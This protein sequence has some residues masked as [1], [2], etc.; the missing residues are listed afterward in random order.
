M[1]DNVVDEGAAGKTELRILEGED[2]TLALGEALGRTL[3]APC[4]V[5]LRGNLGAGKTTLTRGLLRGLGFRGAVKSPTYTIVEPYEL[6]AVTVYH[7]D[8]Y[9]LGSPEELEYMG[10]RDYFGDRTIVIIEWPERG[11]PL[12]PPADIAILLEVAAQ[13][14]ARAV[15]FVHQDAGVHVA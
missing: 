9:R 13:G 12:L 8:L 5:Y 3:R 4:V 6:G 10:I 15:T 14:G 2:A 7:F 11:H 1:L